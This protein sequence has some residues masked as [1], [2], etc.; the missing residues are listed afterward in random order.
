[1]NQP[2]DLILY[3]ATGY[4]GRLVAEELL[5]QQHANKLTFRW[6]LAGRNPAKLERV[7]D[8]LTAIDLRAQQL[9]I[10]VA[11]SSDARSLERLVQQTRVVCTTVGPYMQHGGLLIEACA[12]HGVHYCDLT[13]EVP[14][15]RRAIDDLHERAQKNE[16]RIV[17]CCGFDSIPSDLGWLELSQHL[18]KQ[19]ILFDEIRFFLMKSRGGL[20]GGT[21]ASMAGLFERGLDKGLRRLLFNPVALNPDPSLK[22]DQPFDQRSPRLDSSIGAW[23]APFLMEGI[24]TRVVRRS[25]ALMQESFRYSESMRTGKGPLGWLRASALTLFIG[26]AIGLFSNRLTRPMFRRL[27]PKPGDGPTQR[28]REAGLF[29]ISLLAMNTG[30]STTKTVGRINITCDQDPG[31][32]ATAKMLASSALCLALDEEQLPVRF[33]ILTPASAMGS[34]LT[35]RLESQGI[36][37]TL[38]ADKNVA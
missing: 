7:R 10:V 25:Q 38:E 26:T 33:G 2:F 31:Y 17:P 35:K 11:D 1:M 22:S 24:N 20:S 27:L 12:D 19:S 23:T 3:G 15:I 18:K 6:A 9:P 30:G 5:R 21:I 13:G 4:T 14:F 34:T 37:F 28:Q 32:G 8:E 36:H 29:V 16:A